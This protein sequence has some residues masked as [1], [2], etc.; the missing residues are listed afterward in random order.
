MEWKAVECFGFVEFGASAPN[1]VASKVD[2]P[3]E[4]YDHWGVIRRLWR[5]VVVDFTYEKLE[6]GPEWK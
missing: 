4:C 3:E 5:E 6:H 2:M 1:F